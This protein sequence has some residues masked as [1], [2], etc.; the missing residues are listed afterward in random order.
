[1]CLLDKLDGQNF[2][3]C[4]SSLPPVPL[5][6]TPDC[7]PGYSCPFL[8]VN[9][10]AT[11]PQYCPPTIECQF[12]RLEGKWCD[13]QGRYEPELCKGG[14][15]CPNATVV[16]P[17]PPGY[18]CTRGT[19]RPHP[20]MP[21]SSCPEG[22]QT[23]VFFGGAVA[24]GLV[25]ALLVLIFVWL[26]CVREPALFKRYARERR[27]DLVRAAKSLAPAG[28]A[29]ADAAA[30]PR[31]LASPRVAT[32][33]NPLR[34]PAGALEAGALDAGDGFEGAGAARVSDF[35]RRERVGLWAKLTGSL[36]DTINGLAL[37]GMDMPNGLVVDSGGRVRTKSFRRAS[38]SGPLFEHLE[39]LDAGGASPALPPARA[40]AGASSLMPS[41][42]GA[43]LSKMLRQQP[44]G[45]AQEQARD[46]LQGLAQ[47]RA[48]SAGA[49][50]AKAAEADPLD[51]LVSRSA[52]LVLEDG[53]RRCNAGLRLGIE[54]TG[55]RL[56]LPP[57]ISKTIL[58]DVT[59]RIQPG[60]VTAIMGPS[61]AGKTTFLSVL[62]GKL[63]R[64]AGTLEINGVP[65]EL[66]TFCSITGF[67]PQE[68]TMLRE[69]TV[70]E[71]ISHSAR[72]RL[73]RHG[74]SAESVARLVDAVIEVLGLRSCADTPTARVSGGQRKRAN[75]GMEL[76]MAPAAIFLDEP[77]SGLDATAALEVCNT[78][79]AIA[80]LGLTVVA[81][82]HQPRAEIFRSF[83]DLLLLAPGGKTV[84][85][86]PQRDVMAYFSTAGFAFGRDGNPADDLLDFIAGRDPLHVTAAQ[87]QRARV[88][89]EA[90]DRAMVVAVARASAERA[91]RALG[92]WDRVRSAV[93]GAPPPDRLREMVAKAEIEA[94]GLPPASGAHVEAQLQQVKQQ[95][96]QM[97]ALRA[98]LQLEREQAAQAAQ[99]AQAEQA[100]LEQREH[101]ERDAF[102]DD[103]APAQ[104]Q[105]VVLSMN[106]LQRLRADGGAGAV[107]ED[108]GA[109]LP[110][111][112]SLL[113]QLAPPPAKPPKPLGFP[114][115]PSSSALAS[116]A[117]AAAAT[118]AAGS[119]A[120]ALIAL[121]DSE[122]A[123]Y[124]A[125][126][127]RVHLADAESRQALAALPGGAA[128]DGA[129]APRRGRERK[130]SGGGGSGEAPM[131]PSSSHVSSSSS[132]YFLAPA[133]GVGAGGADGGGGSPSSSS[134][135]AAKAWQQFA[136]SANKTMLAFKDGQLGA[137]WPGGA[138]ASA[139][140]PGSP[141][142]LMMADRGAT[143]SSQFLLCHS[144]SLL[145][146]YRQPAWLVLEL[147]VSTAAGF[148]MGLA[149][150]AVD[151]L[152][153]GVLRQPYTVLSPAPMETMLPS[154][155]LYINI[156]IG[157]AG[158]PAAVRTFGEER[159]VFM[160]EYEGGHSIAAYFWAKNVS[161]MYRITLAALHFSGTFAMMARPTSQF[162][163]TF[164]MV[165]GLFFGVY[166]LAM[167]MSMLVDRA[168]AA[169]LGT[170]ASLI[171]AC[172]CG[173]GPNL[174][175]GREWGLIIVQDM[176]YSRWA[177]ELWMHSETLL[178][179]DNFLVS[180]ITAEIFGYTLDRPNIDIIA[181]AVIGVSMRVLALVLL[182]M[183]T[184]RAAAEAG[185]A[186]ATDVVRGIIK[187]LS[188]VP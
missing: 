8:D 63:P 61:G 188:A 75:I 29:D 161:V 93:T 73:P 172:M 72:V 3:T 79:R 4:S 133:D 110:A 183:L 101:D 163:L 116:A 41:G 132:S 51:R 14:Y 137:G 69:L 19:V 23:P 49:D 145:Q 24:S 107:G 120:D 92:F 7:A 50:A 167:V 152:Y 102:G 44:A 150:F 118:A 184:R 131:S 17:C 80:N 135:S 117:E 128:G 178:Y 108:G 58:S 11:W 37:R 34:A 9:D 171:V 168:N 56:T 26:R 98:E 119:G 12:G 53:F 57:P 165:F 18:F 154:L 20:C 144:R 103:A 81:V 16:L 94:L 84:Y 88:A 160:R 21:L 134:S 166:G 10:T 55:L 158:S 76:A 39:D 140:S 148:I 82:I 104:P 112:G 124:L 126:L 100:E 114:Q 125:A 68:D 43:R 71:N 31:A 78:L 149:A 186:S 164:A 143:F 45:G 179:R 95:Q 54:F 64:T 181:M 5:S 85:T 6:D 155:G 33:Q 162:G 156:A 25:D 27:Q 141:L 187:S 48:A 142:A 66:S 32:L 122:V 175:Q 180:E 38:G 87:L 185:I 74:W 176:S 123:A 15:Y 139:A 109:G 30:S 36:S 89:N 113:P 182:V 177:N 77:T 59:G 136:S 83:D 47:A 174:R 153:S 40:G 121:H 170:I 65:D 146:Q 169:L 111:P 106:P 60:R 28:V 70:R 129:A 62:M 42:R 91:A 99:A 97:Q 138:P 151:E 157:V 13:R 35:R 105:Q 52:T 46:S 159:D 173:F 86:G 96:A 130:N 90:A 115:S 22:T 67:V 147:A 1:M 2:S 127:W